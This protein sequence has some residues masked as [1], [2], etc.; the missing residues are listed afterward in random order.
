MI[1]V[2]YLSEGQSSDIRLHTSARINASIE[3]LSPFGLHGKLSQAERSTT[4]HVDGSEVIVDIESTVSFDVSLMGLEASS[5][6]SESSTWAFPFA[7]F[8]LIFLILADES[9]RNWISGEIEREPVVINGKLKKQCKNFE[10]DLTFNGLDSNFFSFLR[11][12]FYSTTDHELLALIIFI[13]VRVRN[14]DDF[15]RA[16]HYGVSWWGCPWWGG[17]AWV[18]L[19]VWAQVC[20]LGHTRGRPINN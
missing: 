19:V 14:D 18:P 1:R 20:C 12:S 4:V 13:I 9:D 3:Y 2:N 7:V 10:Q 8:L 15:G 17:I 16:C 5:E 6:T 11:F